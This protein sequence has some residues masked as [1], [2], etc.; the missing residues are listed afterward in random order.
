MQFA[1]ARRGLPSAA[2]LRRWGLEVASSQVNVK[3]R[4]DPKVIPFRAPN[5]NSYV[6][7]VYDW[8]LGDALVEFNEHLS[9]WKVAFNNPSENN[10]RMLILYPPAV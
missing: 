4:I 6:D 2:T 5:W 8:F 9:F 10:G 7:S 3:R 1:V